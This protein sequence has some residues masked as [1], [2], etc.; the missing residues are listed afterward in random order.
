[1]FIEKGIEKLRYGGVN[2][3]VVVTPGLMT[4]HRLLWIQNRSTIPDMPA[5]FNGEMNA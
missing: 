1:M 4:L 3:T 5:I 2:V